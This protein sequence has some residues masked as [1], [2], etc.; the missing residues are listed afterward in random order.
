MIDPAALNMED[1]DDED[2]ILRD[3][4]SSSVSTLD[5]IKTKFTRRRSPVS[6]PKARSQTSVIGNSDEELA[7]RAELKRIMHK[8]IQEELRS[9]ET[10]ASPPDSGIDGRNRDNGSLR[11][12]SRG[13]PRDTIEFSVEE[14]NEIK[15]NGLKCASPEFIPFALPVD[16]RQMMAL[17]RRASILESTRPSGD[18]IRTEYYAILLRKFL[19]TIVE[20]WRTRLTRIRTAPPSDQEK[21]VNPQN[22]KIGCRLYGLNLETHKKTQRSRA[23]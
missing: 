10:K 15:A 2:S 12:F 9:E 1:S 13:G 20:N 5:I 16:E 22:L 4:R 21:H 14:M 18:T 8:R 6:D 17:R 3:V 7:R 19:R 11:D 23:N